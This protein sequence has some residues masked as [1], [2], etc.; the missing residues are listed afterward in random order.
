LQPSVAVIFWCVSNYKWFMSLSWPITNLT[1]TNNTKV[2]GFTPLSNSTYSVMDWTNTFQ[3][4]E[5]WITILTIQACTFKL[6]HLAVQSNFLTTQ[7]QLKK[8]QIKHTHH[9]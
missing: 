8:E 2:A 6:K 5:Y 3:R 7:Y 1:T 4:P 9:Y